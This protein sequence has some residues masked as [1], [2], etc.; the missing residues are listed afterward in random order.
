MFRFKIL[1]AAGALLAVAA[2]SALANTHSNGFQNTAPTAT[3]A[4]FDGASINNGFEVQNV[5]FHG[6]RGFSR[7]RGF[8]GSRGFHG[9]G[10]HGKSFHGHKSFHGKGFHANN[11]FRGN[12]F[13]GRRGVHGKSFSRRGGFKKY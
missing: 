13:H 3:V 1:L 7:G 10:F 6:R 9:K 12:S 4:V 5:K 2:P 11:G 8:H